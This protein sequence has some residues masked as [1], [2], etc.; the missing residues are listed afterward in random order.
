MQRSAAIWSGSALQ[1]GSK[2]SEELW[3]Y[4][5][6]LPGDLLECS[7][8]GELRRRRDFTADGATAVDAVKDRRFGPM[9]GFM[10]VD[11]SGP[12]PTRLG[13]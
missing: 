3:K 6:T 10:N 1:G 9:N 2:E 11:H 4:F 7:T 8:E 12:R 13:L 5:H